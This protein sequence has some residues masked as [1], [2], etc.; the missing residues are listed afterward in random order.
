ML[1]GI[2][3]LGLISGTLASVFGDHHAAADPA[4]D[5]RERDASAADRG[6][7]TSSPSW[8]PCATSWPASSNGSRRSPRWRRRRSRSAPPYPRRH[9]TTGRPVLRPTPACRLCEAGRLRSIGRA[10]G[11]I[12]GE[13]PGARPPAR[14]IVDGGNMGDADR[15]TGQR[16]A[17]SP[18]PPATPKVH[19]ID[20]A[21]IAR[22][23]RA[24][25]DKH[26]ATWTSYAELCSAM[27]MTRSS[28]GMIAR[29][30]IFEPTGTHWFRIR[31]DD[32]VYEPPTR[33]RGRRRGRRARRAQ[34]GRGGR[35][36]DRHRR[37]RRR[38]AG[39]PASQAGLERERLD[40]PRVRLTD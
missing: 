10:T 40:A 17:T 36:A 24:A 2:A 5:P 32:G 37:R 31:T 6:D 9:A 35:P 16:G 38:R 4:E 28:A 25:L 21:G 18:R 39:R 27:G 15:L 29:Q 23:A 20:T 22:T 14:G 13:V 19:P 30:H 34:R 8:P 7:A 12:T 33:P 26:P 3:T 11:R 1:T